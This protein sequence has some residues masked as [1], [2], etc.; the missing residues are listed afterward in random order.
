M[1]HFILYH[2]PSGKVFWQAT[3]AAEV[4]S[5]AQVFPN[6]VALS[7]DGELR[8][9]AEFAVFSPALEQVARMAEAPDD[10]AQRAYGA[11]HAAQRT[12]GLRVEEDPQ[13]GAPRLRMA[14]SAE[15]AA[16][17]GRRQQLRAKERVLEI[18]AELSTIQAAVAGGA[19]AAAFADDV[20]RLQAERA[21]LNQRLAG[22][23]P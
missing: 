18:A 10:F 1:P 9:V 20:T 22:A 15:R 13:T 16:F 4:T 23:R 7:V 14:S 6:V 17:E 12:G 3:Q 5:V 2:R 8:P 11:L 19:P 21:A